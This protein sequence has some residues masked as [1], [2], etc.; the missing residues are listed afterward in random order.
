MSELL[1]DK[2]QDD[3]AMRLKAVID[4]LA[5]GETPASVKKEFHQLIK[6]AS[7]EEIASMEQALID[8][9]LPVEEVQR[10]C[11]VHAD[12]FKE[13][14]ERQPKAA[15]MPGHPVHTYMAENAEA[16]RRLWPLRLAGIL[17]SPASIG[18]ADRKSV[19]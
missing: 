19:V 18:K 5:A 13:G 6:G 8:G 4:K 11:E 7:A 17:G 9:G 10:L 2:G 14:L 15:R 3:G 12:V 1:G 16:R